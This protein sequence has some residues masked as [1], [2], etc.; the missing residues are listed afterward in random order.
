M[1]ARRTSACRVRAL[2]PPHLHISHML[3][4]GQC[5]WQP[6]CPDLW[7]QMSCTGVHAADTRERFENPCL[8]PVLL[9]EVSLLSCFLGRILVL[10][11][12]ALCAHAAYRPGNIRPRVVPFQI[13]LEQAQAAFE[14]W[15]RSHWLAPSRL[16]RQGLVSMRAVLLPFWLFEA[17]V[18]VQYTGKPCLPFAHVKAYMLSDKKWYFRKETS[19]R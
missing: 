4:S 9:P 7:A 13:S 19:I 3:L 2:N 1:P 14:Q 11:S 12:V 6:A 18:H 16:L 15:Q 17:T 8:L 5:M 10:H